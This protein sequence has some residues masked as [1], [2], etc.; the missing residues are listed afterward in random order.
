MVVAVVVD[1]DV[2]D[3]GDVVVA[4]VVVVVD[5]AVDDGA[6]VVVVVACVVE[7]ADVVV[8]LDGKV[9]AGA[10]VV[11]VIGGNV[12][13]GGVSD[14]SMANTLLSVNPDPC[15]TTSIFHK[16]GSARWLPCGKVV[17]DHLRSRAHQR[18]L[19]PRRSGVI[20]LQTTMSVLSS[21][22]RERSGAAVR[23]RAPCPRQ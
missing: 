4:A 23:T 21:F 1:G 2:V 22:D 15:S 19:I 10:N 6:S 8:V 16:P 17:A 12:M 20:A 3:P 14:S 13:I 11:V 18:M 9:V 7:G 5:A